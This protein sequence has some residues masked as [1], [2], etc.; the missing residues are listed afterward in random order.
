MLKPTIFR[1]YDIR[2][3]ADADLLSPDIELLGQAIGA[4]VRRQAGDAV[5]VGGDCRLSSPRLRD[6]IATGLVS[7]GCRVTDIGTVPTPVLYHS[8]H[9]ARAAGAVMITGSHNPAEYNGFKTLAGGATLHGESIQQ[10]RRLLE[11]GDLL[12]GEGSRGS[13]DAITPYVD[14]I[15]SRFSWDRRVK[16]VFDTGNGAA[17]PTLHRLLERLNVE[18]IELFSE[19]DGHFPNHHPDPTVEENLDALKAAVRDHQ[20]DFGVA[21]DGDGDRIGAVDEQSRV[22]WGDHL[23]LIFAREILTRKP[24]ATFIGEVK[25]SQVLY[26][27]LEQLGGRPIMYR[28]GHSLIKAKMKEEQAELAGEMSG[29]MFFADRYYG[30]DDALYAACRLMEIVANSGRPLSAQLAGIPVT[31]TTPEL[32]Y[33]CPD[34]LKFDV[35]AKVAARFQA[36][37]DV[38]TVD[39]V[40]ILYPHGWG[41]VRASNTQPVLVLRFEAETTEQLDRYKAEVWAVVEEASRDVTG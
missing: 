2:G 1:E 19:M 31:V 23:L 17:G 16:V 6:A 33:D 29:H 4:F 24:G 18:P 15:A 14:D 10:I 40:R 7:A 35:V 25:C 30:Y 39:G 13:H 9:T 5:T 34:E 41:L 27:Q 28:T 26:D 38:I 8:A 3:I 11:S 32:R 36:T 21:F 20:A 12:T 22:I 37:H